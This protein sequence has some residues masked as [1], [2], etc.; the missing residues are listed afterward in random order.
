MN[1]EISAE[2]L[3]LGILMR[4]VE[5]GWCDAG[6]ANSYTTEADITSRSIV[7][8]EIAQAFTQ[9]KEQ[10]RLDGIRECVGTVLATKCDWGDG[11]R[12]C[13]ATTQRV[14]ENLQSLIRSKEEPK[15]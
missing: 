6:I 2:E 1:K 13:C 8:K 7:L 10:A 15:E 4:M 11:K 14:Y 5:T 3:A 12:A 9:A